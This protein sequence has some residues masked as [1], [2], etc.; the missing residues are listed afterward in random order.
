MKKN[1]VLVIFFIK[2]LKFSKF[3]ADISIAQEIQNFNNLTPFLNSESDS[4]MTQL[5]IS[6]E[7]IINSISA[8]QKMK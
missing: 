3:I 7:N 8:A 2:I 5:A 1:I 4:L 6:D